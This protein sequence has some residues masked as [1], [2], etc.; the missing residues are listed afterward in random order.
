M[1]LNE[2]AVM[3][4]VAAET[5]AFWMK[6]Y[7]AW[8]KCWLH[9][10]EIRMMGWWAR[11]GINITE[12]WDVL[13][14]RMRQLMDANPTP[15]PPAAQVRRE[16]INLRMSDEMAW[17]TFDQ[18]GADSGRTGHG[19]ARAELRNAHSRKARWRVENRLRRMAAER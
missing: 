4:V 8:S 5:T 10:A 11:G 1:D 17:V 16:R 14:S 15:N 12:G 13:S 9:T 3:Q 2:Q 18:Y 7:E 19:Y 6:D